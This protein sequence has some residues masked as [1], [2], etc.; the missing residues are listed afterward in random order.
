MKKRRRIRSV[1][2]W[3]GAAATVLLL[4]AWVGSKWFAVGGQIPPTVGISV[5]TGQMHIR[6]YEPWSLIPRATHWGAQ[7]NDPDM[8]FRWWFSWLRANSGMPTL[9]IVSVPI[10]ILILVTSVPT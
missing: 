8:P 10:W 6:W 9:T 1:I 5:F 7:V 2:K 4:I 3:G